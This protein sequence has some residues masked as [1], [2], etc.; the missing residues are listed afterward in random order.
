MHILNDDHVKSVSYIYQQLKLAVAH[1]SAAYAQIACSCK[2]P[3]LKKYGPCLSPPAE[4]SKMPL[5]VITLVYS[6]CGELSSN[7]ADEL[8]PIC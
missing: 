6:L 1:S 3:S 2:L 5:S 8:E 7:K 4:V